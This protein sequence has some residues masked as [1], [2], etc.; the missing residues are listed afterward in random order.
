[1]DVSGITTIANITDSTI[2]TNGALV[3]SGGLGIAKS[4]FVGTTLNVAGASIL[5]NTLNVTGIA[6]VSNTTDSTI[7]TDGALVVSGGLG[8]AKKCFILEQL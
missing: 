2:S 1:M 4:C 3:V 5:S 8:I 7:S 6:T